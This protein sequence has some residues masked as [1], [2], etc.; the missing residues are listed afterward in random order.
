V[1]DARRAEAFADAERVAVSPLDEW[2][3]DGYLAGLQAGGY[4][5]LLAQLDDSSE[6]G[7]APRCWVELD[8]CSAVP[9]AGGSSP[10]AELDGSS[11]DGC[12]RDD[13]LAVG[14]PGDSAAWLADG[15]TLP[16]RL[17]ADWEQAEWAGDSFVGWRVGWQAAERAVPVAPCLAGW[18][19]GLWSA[20]RVCLEAPA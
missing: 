6:D 18:R 14:A 10:A 4:S 2:S 13:W 7:T 3:R 5:A 19:D 1:A 12:S 17:G 9:Q 15:S 8:G 11:R 16:A 20:S